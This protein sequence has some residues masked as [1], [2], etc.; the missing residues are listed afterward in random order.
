[1]VEKTSISMPKQLLDDIDDERHSTVSRSEWIRN[2]ARKHLETQKA[3]S[4]GSEPEDA[5]ASA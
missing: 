1:M 5:G 2:A 3:D 4:S